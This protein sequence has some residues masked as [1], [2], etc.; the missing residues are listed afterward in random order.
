MRF[1]LLSFIMLL[2]LSGQASAFLDGPN[3][4]VYWKAYS[5]KSQEGNIVSPASGKTSKG[6][7]VLLALTVMPPSGQY[8]YGPDSTEGL[9]TMVD[10]EYAKLAT[11][12]MSKMQ[13]KDI[14]AALEKGKTLA[15]VR[16]PE[17]VLKSDSAFSS[18]SL[19]G[20]EGSNPHIF[21][22]PATFWAELPV[23]DGLGGLAARVTVSGLLCSAT[24]CMPALGEL[25]L[26]FS[27]T[28]MAAFPAASGE[29]WWA[30][31]QTGE[32]VLVPPPD[33]A[34]AQEFY[35]KSDP[36]PFTSSKKVEA[37]TKGDDENI[38]PEALLAS[39]QPSFFNPSLEVEFLGQ[40]LFFGIIA[41]ML[42]NL[43]PCV[44]PVVSLKFTALLAVSSMEDKKHQARAFR[45]H[46]LIFAAGILV[47]FGIM[48][49]FIGVAGWAWGEVF[50]QPMIIVGLG[51]VL[52][53]LGLS[54][55]GVFPLPI[56]DLKV[57]SNSHPHW[58]A[59]GSGLLATLLATPC[60]GPLLGGVL[61]WAIR[62]P[63]PVLILTVSSVGV[64]MA[65]PYF[66]MAY[67]PRL[68]HL[69]P[70]PGVW[71]LRL[72]Q[73]L[74]FFLMGTVVYL[75][76]L[77]PGEWLP[78]FLFNLTAVA[79]ACWLWGQ[80]GS[81]NASRTTRFVARLAAVSVVLLAVWWGRYSLH[82]DSEWESFDPQAFSEMI[83]KQPLLLEFTADWCPSCKA[84]EYTT[85]NKK[86]MAD[87]RR[88]YNIRAIR[89]DLTREDAV[90]KSLLK[91]L[92]SSSIP[93]IALFPVGEN[94][95]QPLVLRDIVT[96]SQLEAAASKMFD[97]TRFE[98]LKLHL[99]TRTACYIPNTSTDD[100][101]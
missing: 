79:F 59:F 33:E 76:T 6:N 30:A 39:I 88:R 38:V 15:P 100:A 2:M 68:V 62:Q 50:Q 99:S 37:A 29:T 90:G 69:L 97:D 3:C 5:L 74:G 82:Q 52:F 49:L 43:M 93:V 94:S 77:L 32:S 83:G 21:P 9:P 86:R 35:P 91:A 80:I 41:G 98:N 64:G 51:L 14:V 31:L 87:L 11:Y 18:Y 7:R 85:L 16:N 81:L 34:Y 10:V 47:W 70:R 12:P 63:L 96:P 65:M 25:D 54:L 61:A 26:S 20:S 101:F 56:F 24:S 1:W 22:G 67:C 28:E 42:L 53:V 57:T 72:E 46:C 19:P 55:F 89:V 8:L 95:R 58:Q 66:V 73:L 75:A 44:L 60:S 27:A 92:D 23:V 78:A 45:I 36:A 71:T 4:A 48:A 84:L 17:P 13:S 40:A